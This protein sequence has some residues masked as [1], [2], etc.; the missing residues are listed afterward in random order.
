M[1]AWKRELKA[2]AA[3]VQRD[4]NTLLSKT[5]LVNL[6]ARNTLI[7][8]IEEEYGYRHWFWNPAMTIE[9]F[10]QWWYDLVSVSP[11]FLNPGNTLPGMTL[12][13][14][15]E[16]YLVLSNFA[17]EFPD[18]IHYFA[19]LHED[20]DSMLQCYID[21]EII[22][23]LNRRKVHYWLFAT[24]NGLVLRN[25]R[26]NAIIINPSNKPWRVFSAEMHVKKI[27]DGIFH[28]DHSCDDY[29]IAQAMDMSLA[30]AIKLKKELA[31]KVYDKLGKRNGKEES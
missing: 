4:T 3:D 2:I 14:T 7:V 21:G 28:K 10:K 22:E 23:H 15:L 24:D 18:K 26:T 25:D 27:L 16:E 19:H 5:K 17:K 11:F 9:E 12:K 13:L 30:E 8:L 6:V 31:K 20:D 29:A 1:T